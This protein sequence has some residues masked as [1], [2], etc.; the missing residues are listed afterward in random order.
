MIKSVR[1][2]EAVVVESRRKSIYNIS[3]RNRTAILKRIANTIDEDMKKNQDRE[4][5][6]ALYAA[7]F[8]TNAVI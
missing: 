7:E 4:S 6:S 2:G 5:V 8:R 3:K 1:I